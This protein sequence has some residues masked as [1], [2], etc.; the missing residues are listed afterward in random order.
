VPGEVFVDTLFVVALINQR[1]AYHDEAVRLADLME[2]QSL[3]TTDAVLLEI[4][5][6]LARNFRREAIEVI[7]SFLTS[8]E[9]EIIR[10]TPALFSKAYSI[11]KQHRDKEWGLVDCVSFAVMRSAGVESALTFDQHFIQAGFS[12]LMRV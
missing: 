1:D 7:D 12:A 6:A 10:M 3:V 5:N 8:K 4:G 9:V 2:G 11:Y